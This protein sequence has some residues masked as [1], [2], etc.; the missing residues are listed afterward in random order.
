MSL[1]VKIDDTA[2]CFKHPL[3]M[4]ENHVPPPSMLINNISDECSVL[5]SPIKPTP[6]AFEQPPFLS[7]YGWRRDNIRKR[8]CLYLCLLKKLVSSV[9]SFRHG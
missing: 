6:M 8:R 1:V 2:S 3:P 5:F 7:R 9:Y 4:L